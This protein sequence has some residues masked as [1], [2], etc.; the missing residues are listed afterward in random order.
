M[1]SED[2]LEDL[3][4][5]EGSSS[6]AGSWAGSEEEAAVV[7]PDAA[8][9]NYDSRSKRVVSDAVGKSM[10]VKKNKIAPGVGVVADH[11]HVGG[12]DERISCG[13]PGVNAESSNSGGERKRVA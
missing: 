4:E 8:P 1:E 3:S 12:R 11:Y 9:H 6:E 5:P 13:S 7:T 10:P 2:R